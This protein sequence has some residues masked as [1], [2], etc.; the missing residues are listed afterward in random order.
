MKLKGPHSLDKFY[1][2]IVTRLRRSGVPC[3]ITGGLACAQFGT[4][5]H[6]EDCDLILAANHGETLLKVLQTSPYDRAGCRYRKS[7]PPLD[8]R[9]LAGGFTSHFYWSSAGPEKPYLDVFCAP[10]RVSSPWERETT[11]LFASMHT[12]AEMKRTKRRKDWDQA[13]ALGIK[14][15]E[16]GD[17]RGWLHIFD[18]PALRALIRQHS[19]RKEELRQRP[20]LQLALEGSPLLDRAI[21]TEVEFWTH[22]DALR[23]RVYQDCMEPYARALLKSAKVQ[24]TDLQGQHRVRVKYAERLLPT[25]PLQDY[26]ID[27]LI[28]EAKQATAIGL[29]PQILRYLPSATP[30]FANIT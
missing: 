12:V 21:Q 24:P 11:G 25:R 8:V 19:P 15:L 28:E 5:E 7:S 10:P 14:M 26:G 20:I 6:T 23:L 27:R 1:A 29:D 17:E 13:T 4:V 2:A 30:H 16:I 3:A 9:W 18:G 22:L